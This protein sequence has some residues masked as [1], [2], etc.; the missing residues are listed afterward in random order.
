MKSQESVLL[1]V[2]RGI[3]KDVQAA[4]PAMRGLD[5]DF[6]RLT[7]QCQTRGQA[8]FMLDLPHLDALLLEGLECGRLTS[9]GPLSSVVSKEVKV[10]RFSQDFGYA[11]LISMHVCVRMPTRLA[12]FFLGSFAA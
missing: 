11:C 12:Y 3:L 8:L 6:E 7:L 2:V 4:Y 5:L 10:P 1:H 9:K